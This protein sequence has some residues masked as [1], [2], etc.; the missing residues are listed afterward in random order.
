MSTAV[1]IITA[2]VVQGF[3]KEIT[4]K[5]VGFGAHIDIGHYSKQQFY[6]RVPME[7]NAQIEDMKG[8][9]NVEH[10]QPYVSKPGILKNGATIQANVLK[11]VD[12]TYRWDF[13]KEHLL[14]GRLD[15]GLQG[16]ILI[17]SK[18]ATALELKVGE[19]VLLYF[20]QDPPRVRKLKVM[21]IYK[22]G[23]GQFDDLMAFV[24]IRLLQKM[25]G[26]T[27][28]QYGGYELLVKD[29]DK[30]QES[31]DEIYHAIPASLDALS[32]YQQFPDIFNWLELQDMNYLIIIVLMILVA[33]INSISSLVIM[34]LEK[35]QAIG[36]LK[37]L[38]ASNWNIKRI[39]IYQGGYL[40]VSGLFWGNLFGIGLA[41]IQK[42]WGIVQLNIESYYLPS[43]PV[44]LKTSDLLFI[45]GGALI[46]CM[47][48]LVLP[49]HLVSKIVI[50]R[51]I[52]F[53]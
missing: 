8:K 29:F 52:K 23:F 28:D 22:S 39:F 43:V 5:V 47:A 13:F 32:I 10:V 49:S 51:V 1:M 16:G 9:D 17:S 21:G 19:K 2:A 48:A 44:L 18:T 25:N 3:K 37:T 11:G 34:I 7:K 50:A 24:D 38:G 4:E 45:N 14:S 53:D 40:L 41:L 30:V 31:A 20:I 33:A 26:W 42:E 46:L 36:V 12:S 27:E 15:S 6:E 35:T